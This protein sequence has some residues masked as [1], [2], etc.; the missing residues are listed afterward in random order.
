MFVIFKVSLLVQ[1]QV[2]VTVFYGP[3]KSVQN[4]T[5]SESPYT[6]N[7]RAAGAGLVRQR[8]EIVLAGGVVV[9]EA[10][11]LAPAVPGGQVLQQLACFVQQLQLDT[12]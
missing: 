10:V 4:Y 5:A 7:Y 3:T 1:D 2:W 11:A 12:S 8:D 6:P 9:Q